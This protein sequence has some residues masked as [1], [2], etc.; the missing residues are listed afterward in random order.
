MQ[1]FNVEIFDRNFNFIHNYTIE[2]PV[3]K[4]D[5]LTPVENSVTISFN[6]NVAVGQYIVIANSKRRFEGVISSYNI[7]ND[8]IMTV[9][10][11]PLNSLFKTTCYVNGKYQN[12]EDDAG[13]KAIEQVVYEQ[14]ERMFINGYY[15]YPIEYASASVNVADDLQKIPGLTLTKSSTTNN[16]FIGLDITEGSAN[17]STDFKTSGMLNIKPYWIGQLYD[18][19]IPRVMKGCGIGVIA[20]L[21]LM[22]QKV[23]CKIGKFNSNTITIES[24][25]PHILKKNI[26]E[27]DTSSLANKYVELAPSE[28]GED[29]YVYYRHSDGTWDRNN[30]DRLSP[31][32]AEF[33]E[34]GSD[35]GTNP[36]IETQL[37]NKY[38]A[39]KYVNLIELT[40]IID[41]YNIEIGDIANIIVGDKVYESMLTGYEIQNNTIKYI[42]GMLR[43]DLTKILKRRSM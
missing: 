18:D 33:K 20:S 10:Y 29:P 15:P 31:V 2:S 23:N 30:T 27:T 12:G 37:F 5:Y 24:D 6:K 42:F 36:P 8:K 43:L 7:V 1:P 3:Y 32:I 11:M 41:T 9:N 34:A 39:L 19:I 28:S 21:D 40:T 26:V 22:Q 38:G 16:W 13:T 35:M 17:A 4:Y 25:L 14:I